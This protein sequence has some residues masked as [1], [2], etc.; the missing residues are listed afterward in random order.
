MRDRIK[1][2]A[3]ANKRSMNAE[4]VASLAEMHPE[5]AAEW[6]LSAIDSM[7]KHIVSA[8]SHAE[9]TAR[10]EAAN[11]L[12]APSGARLSTALGSIGR[13]ELVLKTK[14]PTVET[15]MTVGWSDDDSTD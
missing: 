5:P 3:E 2:A 15:M 10:L 6:S 8:K 14:T 4:I 11:A 7:I 1:N 13:P 9:Y 12:L